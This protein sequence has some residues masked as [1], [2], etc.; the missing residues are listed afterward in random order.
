MANLTPKIIIIII[1]MQVDSEHDGDSKVIQSSEE[2]VVV[3]PPDLVSRAA[4][5]WA[6]LLRVCL[7]Y[8]R[9]NALRGLLPQTSDV[10][11]IARC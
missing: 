5:D 9:R 1:I 3:P 8:H 4:D 6:C 10:E 2:I 7:Y 11:H